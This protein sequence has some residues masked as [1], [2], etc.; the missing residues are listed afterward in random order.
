MVRVNF[1]LLFGRRRGHWKN[2]FEAFLEGR[3]DFVGRR[4]R[5]LLNKPD[6]EAALTAARRIRTGARID[7]ASTWDKVIFFLEHVQARRGRTGYAG[8]KVMKSSDPTP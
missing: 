5:R 4:A 1:D 3:N 6:L 7:H 2:D 8:G